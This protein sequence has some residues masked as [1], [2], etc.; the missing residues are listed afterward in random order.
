[1]NK[2]QM[3]GVAEVLKKRF[4][5]LSA[6]ETMSMCY[7]IVE[8]VLAQATPDQF[9]K[10]S[11]KDQNDKIDRIDNVINNPHLIDSVKLETIDNIVRE[12]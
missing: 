7:D 10:W 2:G 5:N 3:K 11:N 6:S 12:K 1:M 4:N 9:P 8:V